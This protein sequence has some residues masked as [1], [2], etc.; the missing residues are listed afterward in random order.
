MKWLVDCTPTPQKTF[1]HWIGLFTCLCLDFHISHMKNVLLFYKEPFADFW[2]SHLVSCQSDSLMGGVG[3]PDL[4]RHGYLK[5]SP[6]K[7]FIISPLSPLQDDCLRIHV[8]EEPLCW[9]KDGVLAKKLRKW[10]KFILYIIFSSCIILALELIHYILFYESWYVHSL[11]CFQILW[12]S[13]SFIP[14]L[15]ILLPGPLNARIIL[16][17]E[18]SL[19]ADV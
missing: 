13:L 7:I 3:L 2:L 10:Q 19:L 1:G 9:I 16:L 12:Y 14:E 17:T 5:D 11:F 8:D 15:M 18:I 4:C 6:S